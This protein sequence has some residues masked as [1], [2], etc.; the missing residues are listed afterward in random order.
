M[1]SCSHEV[2]TL[3]ISG[4]AESPATAATALVEHLGVDHSLLDPVPYIGSRRF[5]FVVGV[6]CEI[7]DILDF[8]FFRDDQSCH[9]SCLLKGKVGKLCLS[10]DG[11]VIGVEIEG[12]NDQKIFQVDAKPV[13]FNSFS[14]V[15]FSILSSVRFELIVFLG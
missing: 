10:V 15:S 12:L 8:R 1:V 3:D 7:F 6:V 4:C 11:T 14:F 2:Q 9:G 5:W 13:K